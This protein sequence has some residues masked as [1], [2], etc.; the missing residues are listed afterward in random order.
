[1]QSTVSWLRKNRHLKVIHTRE[2][3]KKVDTNNRM[4]KILSLYKRYIWG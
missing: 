2:E 3:V 4:E 1:M